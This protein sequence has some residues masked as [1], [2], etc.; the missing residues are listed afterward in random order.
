MYICICKDR[1]VYMY[2]YIYIYMY[3]YTNILTY[4]YIHTYKHTYIYIDSRLVST[5]A[6]PSILNDQ[7]CIRTELRRMMR[8][9]SEREAQVFIYT[10]LFVCILFIYIYGGSS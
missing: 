10:C 7:I 5:V 4:T 8:S 1:Y 9:L 3:I 2:I 6:E